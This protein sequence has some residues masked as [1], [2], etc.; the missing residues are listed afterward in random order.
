MNEAQLKNLYAL[1]DMF[2]KRYPG[3]SPEAIKETLREAL[4]S[5]S[6]V[7]PATASEQDGCQR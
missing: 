1:L 4:K 6:E 3:R 5:L 2:A 7:K